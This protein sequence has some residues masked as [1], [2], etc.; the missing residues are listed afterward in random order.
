MSYSEM[1]FGCVPNA[2]TPEIVDALSRATVPWDA[3]DKPALAEWATLKPWL[4]E[5]ADT[6]DMVRKAGKYIP[7]WK[8]CENLGVQA[9]SLFVPSQGSIGS[10]AGVS[11]FDRCYQATLLHQIATGSEQTIEPVNAMPTW[12]ISKNWSRRGGQ[13]IS[14]VVREGV[15]TGVF[16]AAAVGSYSANWYDSSAAEKYIYDAQERQMGASLV[17]DA[18][19]KYAAVELALRAGLVVEVGQS[20]A[21]NG[22][23]IDANGVPVATLGG[24][25]SHATTFTELVIINGKKYLRWDNSHDLIYHDSMFGPAFGALMSVDTAKRFLGGR[26][27]DLAVV[28]Y[29]E[30]PYDEQAATNLNPVKAA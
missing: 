15:S 2:E 28:T 21:V 19:D 14:A 30:S 20:V 12:L 25:W 4:E 18:E 7:W 27:T 23:E 26:W 17:D 1:M 5:R 8:M 29:V 3:A 6:M 10:C 22:S 16:P 9:V 11:Y 13:S 24:S